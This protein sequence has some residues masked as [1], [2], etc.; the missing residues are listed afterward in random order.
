MKTIKLR[1]HHLLCMQFFV[2]HGYNQEF[3]NNLADIINKINK[4]NCLIK[5]VNDNDDVC[6]YCPN[7]VSGICK[8]IDKVK[9]YDENVLKLTSL[10]Y[11]TYNYDEIRKAI[12]DNIVTANIKL[13]S[14]CK[15]CCWINICEKL[16]KERT[17]SN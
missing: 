1:P 16:K 6:K 2:G 7:I 14:V 13:N 8:D 12:L 11:K 17:N 3:V 9:V 5:I 4:E 10:D 15:S